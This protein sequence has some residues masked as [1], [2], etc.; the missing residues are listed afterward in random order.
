MWRPAGPHKLR[1][2][3]TVP[4][5]LVWVGAQAIQRLIRQ[6][7]LPHDLQ[8][9]CCLSPTAGAAKN[10]CSTP[11]LLATDLQL[12][13]AQGLT[14]GLVPAHGLRGSRSYRAGGDELSSFWEK[15]KK[16][17]KKLS[18]TIFRA[19]V[20]S[21]ISMVFLTVAH[22]FLAE[23]LVLP[24]KDIVS[25]FHNLHQ[26]SHSKGRD[27]LLPGILSHLSPTLRNPDLRGDLKLLP[28]PCV[29][30]FLRL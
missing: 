16:G 18:I 2:D 26:H 7:D 19:G 8:L 28:K 24:S 27:G 3:D 12:V 29:S 15:G 21:W 17:L 13:S 25:K 5:W 6:P 10:S 11:Q 20:G 4:V 14:H 23:F 30:H 1:R 9:S 22:G